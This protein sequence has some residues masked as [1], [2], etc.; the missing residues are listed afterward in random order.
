MSNKIRGKFI[1]CKYCG[2]KFKISKNKKN[3][4]EQEKFPCPHCKIDY[5][6][7]PETERK[8]QHIQNKYRISRDE[9]YLKEMH[10]ILISYAESLIKKHYINLINDKSLLSYYAHSAVSLLIEADYLRKKDFYI[11][12]SFGSRLIQKCLQ[13]IQSPK[14]SI[15]RPLEE[16]SLD[17]LFE[18]GHKVNYEDNSRTELDFILEEEEKFILLKKLCELTFQMEE[19]CDDNR[20]NYIR[21]LNIDNYL[22]YGEKALDDFFEIYGRYGKYKTLQSLN[23]IKTELQKILLLDKNNNFFFISYKYKK[24][25]KSPFIHYGGDAGG[26]TPVQ[27]CLP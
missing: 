17:Y 16:D 7:F 3:K 20:E 24:G 6:V 8:L 10:S 25:L 27:K 2:K 9:K 21:L 26:R 4:W 19:F 11:D 5:S 23:I 22:H 1:T 15:E 12:I 13:A 14:E 18:D